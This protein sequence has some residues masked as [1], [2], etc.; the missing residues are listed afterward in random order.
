MDHETYLQTN[1]TVLFGSIHGNQ[2]SD[3]VPSKR[4]LRVRIRVG[5][6]HG[7]DISTP[8]MMILLCTAN[9]LIL[10]QL[11]V[12]TVSQKKTSHFNFRHNF[13]IC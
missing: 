6:V 5:F 1:C 13:A 11:R 9:N 4:R 12:Y 3:G 7:F 8:H 2:T 10:L